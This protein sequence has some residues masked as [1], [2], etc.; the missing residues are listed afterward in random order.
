MREIDLAGYE[1]ARTPSAQSPLRRLVVTTMFDRGLTLEGVAGRG[2]L[3]VATVAALRSGGRG[4]RPRRDTL[5]RLARGLGIP[6]SEVLQAVEGP[7]PD[8]RE[9][10]L[11]AHFRTLDEGRKRQVLA[12]AAELAEADAV[13]PTG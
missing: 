10:V 11:L 4:K 5:E 12:H 2:G 3:S 8:P 1:A 6:L 7:Q 9:Q 13:Q